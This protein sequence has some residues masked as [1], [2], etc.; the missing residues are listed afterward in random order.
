MSLGPVDI[1]AVTLELGGSLG[2]GLDIS[3]TLPIPTLNLSW[4][5]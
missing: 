5:L 2:V 1:N 3:I 4:G